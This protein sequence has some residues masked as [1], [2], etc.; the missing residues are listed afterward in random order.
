VRSAKQSK[1]G[2]IYEG[3]GHGE[4]VGLARKQLLLLS[5]IKDSYTST[6]GALIRLFIIA[7]LKF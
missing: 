4:L 6:H 2:I 7:L 3:Q 5:I 1:S